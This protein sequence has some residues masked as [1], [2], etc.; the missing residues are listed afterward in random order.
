MA[1]K[2]FDKQDL[3]FLAVCISVPL[4]VYYSL[5][6]GFFQQDEWLGY[7]RHILLKGSTLKEL[8]LYAFTPGLGHYTPLTPLLVYLSFSIFGLNYHAHVLISL[9]LH[10]LVIFLFYNFSKFF[11]PKNLA[12][13][14][15]L[16]FGLTATSFQGTAWVVAN[17][18]TQLSSIF[19]L[20]SLIFITKFLTKGRIKFLTLSITVLF[21]SLLF[22]ELTVGLFLV[23]PVAILFWGKFLNRYQKIKYS[24]IILSLG[25]IYSFFR[26]FILFGLPAGQNNEYIQQSNRVAYELIAVPTMSISQTLIP[27]NILKDLSF[28]ITSEIVSQY[29][30]EFTGDWGSPEFE[31]FAVEKILAAVSIIFSVLFIFFAVILIKSKDNKKIA[32]FGIIFVLLNSVVLFWAPE[33][34]GLI[35]AIDSRN[36]YF[37]SIGSVL[38][39]TS[40]L[41]DSLQKYFVY[42]FIALIIFNAYFLNQSLLE[43][44]HKGKVRLWILQE[45]RKEY[46]MLPNKVIFYT[47]SDTSFYG[48]PENERILPFQSGFGQTLL[49]WYYSTHNLPKELFKNKFL[50]EID[51]QGYKEVEDKGFGY[52]RD[53]ELMMKT[54]VDKKINKEAVIAFT[55]D[56][57]AQLITNTSKQVQGRI[58]GYLV[59]KKIV[60]P[61]AYLISAS[62]N[63]NDLIFLSDDRKGTYW[64]SKLPYSQPQY[65]TITLNSPQKIAAIFINSN[66]NKNQDKVGYSIKLS[67]DGLNWNEVFYAKRYPPG[68]E[69]VVN[70]Y[71]EPL[72]AKFI[73]IDQI[74]HHDFASWVIYE[75]EI[76]EAI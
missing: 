69:G 14:S 62:S 70:L 60:P 40:L 64:D 37:I 7:A 2:S 67:M 11:F 6:G 41:S 28:R 65:L 21:V 19:G 58:E 8:I 48:L 57:T 59:N 76:Y 46:P 35:S 1:K 26:V 74:G 56:S 24:F 32:V 27:V 33:K 51:D 31:A 50:W 36:L 52:F 43:F 47:E 25:F 73:R 29:G 3:L 13:F 34:E 71:F 16:L 38:L 61:T 44:N 9:I 66:G 55:Y 17:L 39:I 68:K 30:S 53:F 75:L 12:F 54:M 42:T 20:L 72:S 23:L 63:A 10:A 4:L 5:F 45:I 15:T 22:K 18:G 49:V